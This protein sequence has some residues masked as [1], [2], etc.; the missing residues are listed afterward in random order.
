MGVIVFTSPY[1]S[2]GAATLGEAKGLINL[3]KNYKNKDEINKIKT[4]LKALYNKIDKNSI[5]ILNFENKF[6]KNKEEIDNQIK[7]MKEKKEEMNNIT[8]KKIN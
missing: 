3:E 5:N 6:K 4:K 7:D 1:L 8:Y 2:A